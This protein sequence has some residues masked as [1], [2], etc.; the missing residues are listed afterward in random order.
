M[1]ITKLQALIDET[2]DL[3]R[4]NMTAT[5]EGGKVLVFD[6]HTQTP[7]RFTTV[8]EAAQYLGLE[9]EESAE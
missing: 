3:A 8:R 5:R 6:T 2:P 7:A 4:R 1:T 9:Q